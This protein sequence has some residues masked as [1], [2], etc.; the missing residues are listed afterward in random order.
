[1]L[2]FHMGRDRRLDDAQPLVGAV[3]VMV[4]LVW[5]DLCS[6]PRPSPFRYSLP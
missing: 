4:A 3:Q 2:G 1:M 6:E 5:P